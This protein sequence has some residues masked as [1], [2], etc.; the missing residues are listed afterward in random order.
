MATS[1][2]PAILDG[3]A[4][5]LRVAT[6]IGNVTTRLAEMASNTPLI[7]LTQPRVRRIDTTYGEMAMEWTING[8]LSLPTGNNDQAETD[9]YAAVVAI[10]EVSG[11]DLDA[12][13]AITNGQV[14]IESGNVAYGSITDTPVIA[15]EF[16]IKVVER[17][18]YDYAL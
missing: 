11:H 15:F 14:L 17:V 3:I 9:L 10:L 18:P 1:N 4:A 16:Q 8:R 12:H 5:Q 2:L 13:G 6:G 7:T